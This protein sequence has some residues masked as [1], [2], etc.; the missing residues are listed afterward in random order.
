VSTLRL[1]RLAPPW[2]VV[3]SLQALWREARAAFAR[4]FAKARPTPVQEAQQV[5][6]LAAQRGQDP[7]I[8]AELLAAA[9][10][11]ERLHDTN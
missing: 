4:A 11:H 1:N 2:A 10:R 7:R 6:R 3:A 9:D 8:V 5:R